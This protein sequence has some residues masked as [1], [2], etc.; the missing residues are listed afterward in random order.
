MARSRRNPLWVIVLAE[1]LDCI[2]EDHVLDPESEPKKSL[3]K[4]LNCFVAD[5]ILIALRK[6]FSLTYPRNTFAEG[7]QQALAEIR[8]IGVE[9][10]KEIPEVLQDLRLSP[11]PGT[12]ADAS[13]SRGIV[14]KFS[15][16]RSAD[17]A[18][19][20]KYEG[21]TR[22]LLKLFDPH[23]AVGGELPRVPDLPVNGFQRGPVVR[24]GVDLGVALEA[25]GFGWIVHFLV[26]SGLMRSG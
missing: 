17:L 22:S 6:S 2:D 24:L 21:R 23:P 14:F 16:V 25:S 10:L 9:A 19:Q 11:V 7:L 13:A 1:S 26:S 8:R 20:V 15:L 4:E 12:M 3:L 5:E 18:I